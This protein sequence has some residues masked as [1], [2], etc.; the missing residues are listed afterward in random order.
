MESNQS[1]MSPTLTGIVAEIKTVLESARG[2]VARQVNSELLSAYWNIGRIISEYEQTVPERA[3]YGKQTLKE[4]AKVLTAEFGKGFSRSNLQN[5]RTFYLTYEKCQTLSGKL[6]W[7]HYCELLSVSDP[8]K[9]SFYE[10]EA[11][12]SNWSVRELKRQIDSSLFE[13]LLLSRGD[14]NKEQVLALAH[15]GI[16][17][18][19]PADIIRDPYVFEFLGLPEDKPVMES[20]LERALVQQIEKFLLE[21]G[22]GFMFVGTQQRV[23]VNNTH[24]YVDMVFY[25]KILR[26]YVLIELKTTKLTPE[27]AGQLNMYLNYYAAEVNDSDDN[28]PV[29]IILCTEKDSITAEYA[30]GGLSNNIFA[31]RYVLYIPDKEQLIAQVEAVLGKHRKL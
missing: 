17:I 22:R 28:P 1:I 26:A 2:N 14:A 4:L 5:M 29:G 31:S 19:E 20:D 18:A 6:S 12:N 23:T 27:A 11:V 24:Y 7:S 21:L 10:K 8:D 25:N 13:R 3:D 16:E 30:L 9:R 15:K